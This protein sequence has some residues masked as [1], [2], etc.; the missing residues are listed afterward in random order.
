MVDQHAEKCA[1]RQPWFDDAKCPVLLALSNVVR[2]KVVNALDKIA[3][4]I[5]VKIS[6]PKLKT[7][8]GKTKS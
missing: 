6:K 5:T 3:K 2:D 7:K 8:G 1:N 4:E